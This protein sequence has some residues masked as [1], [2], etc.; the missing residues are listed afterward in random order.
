MKINAYIGTGNDNKMNMPYIK[1]IYQSQDGNK[2][3]FHKQFTLLRG[4][5]QDY[6]SECQLKALTME[7]KKYWPVGL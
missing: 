7:G 1:H 6:I 4:Q 5:D 2:T 3:S